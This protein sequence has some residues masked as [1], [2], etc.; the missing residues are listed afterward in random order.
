MQ[1]IWIPGERLSDNPPHPA[2]VR[3]ESERVEM[4]LK[5]F[6]LKKHLFDMIKAYELSFRVKRLTF[7]TFH[8]FFPTFPCVLDAQSF[9]NATDKNPWMR[10][11]SLFNKF[12]ESFVMERY[13]LLL[14]RYRRECDPERVIY[15]DGGRA[16]PGLPL[17]MIFP[18]DGIHGGL[19][20][21][22]SP[23]SLTCGMKLCFDTRDNDGR[24]CRVWVEKFNDWLEKLASLGWTPES[25]LPRRKFRKK[26][27]IRSRG[28]ILR[29][30]MVK[31]CGNIGPAAYILA[32]L[33]RMMRPKA[34]R[35]ELGNRRL[36]P[37]GLGVTFKQDQ[38]AYGLGLSADQVKR[39]LAELRAKGFIKTDRVSLG[40][41]QNQTFVLLD[42]D[43]IKK[44]MKAV[45]QEL[46]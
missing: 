40:G 39:G 14:D 13:L 38:L 15:V 29:P 8:Q 34:T 10:L 18:C 46:R 19:I 33:C 17:C 26:R 42:R 1:S 21:H 41:F 27:P 5:A 36:T 24:P 2:Q 25:P 44:A 22:N 7:A 12:E 9:F 45:E 30:W 28:A 6:H 37:D 20:M 35:Y 11:A 23:E 32:W 43:A 16:S 4:V 3:Y 31:I